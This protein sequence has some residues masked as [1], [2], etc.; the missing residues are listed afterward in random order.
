MP[1]LENNTARLPGSIARPG[2]QMQSFI[3]WFIFSAKCTC[4]SDVD[5]V[6]LDCGGRSFAGAGL[7]LQR[8]RFNEIRARRGIILS[9]DQC[10]T[11]KGYDVTGIENGLACTLTIDKGPAG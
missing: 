5:G 4:R 7:A 8:S 2:Q 10:N 9:E 11:C 1:I 3:I 6:L